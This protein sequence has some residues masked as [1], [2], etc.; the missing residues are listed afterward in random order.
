MNQTAIAKPEQNS[1]VSISTSAMLCY[2]TDKHWY[3]E[4][5]WSTNLYVVRKGELEKPVRCMFGGKHR[6]RDMLK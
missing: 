1:L 5:P 4:N 3:E 6:V 2:F